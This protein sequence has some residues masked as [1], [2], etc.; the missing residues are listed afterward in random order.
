IATAIWFFLPL[1]KMTAYATFQ[2][3]SQPQS[4]IAPV[5]D[6][7]SDFMVYRQAQAALVKSRTVLNAA[8]NQPG[9]SE[10]PLLAR[11]VDK[12]AWLDIHVK[13]DFRSSPEFMRLS[14]EGD[15]GDSIKAVIEAVAT[16]Y[17]KQ[18]EDREMGARNRRLNKLKDLSR[19]YANKLESFHGTISNWAKN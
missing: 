18:V 5:A 4:L 15:D 13:V 9:M 7:K 2:V 1:P 11:E 17:E 16:A 8:L 6:S 19:E 3:S 12:L 10:N 14:L